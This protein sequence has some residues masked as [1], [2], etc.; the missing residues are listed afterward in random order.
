MWAKYDFLGKSIVYNAKSTSKKNASI[1][2][3]MQIVVALATNA[4][5]L[6]LF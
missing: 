3:K 2:K 5:F 1:R 4:V 6:L